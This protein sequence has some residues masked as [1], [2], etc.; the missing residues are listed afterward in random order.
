MLK[1]G[2]GKE[3]KRQEAKQMSRSDRLAA[4]PSIRRVLRVPE[5][6]IRKP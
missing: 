1:A 6:P 3:E 5:D 2:F 4:K